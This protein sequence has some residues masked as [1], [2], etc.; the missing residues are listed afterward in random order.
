MELP[1]LPKGEGGRG[2]LLTS[3]KVRVASK[4]KLSEMNMGTQDLM[5]DST[6]IKPKSV[7][8]KL[9]LLYLVGEPDG[10]AELVVSHMFKDGGS[11]FLG[12]S[13]ESWF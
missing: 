13:C 12:S 5:S 8:L 10:K 9:V 2:F 4:R 6:G 7:R 3:S 1:S 11:C